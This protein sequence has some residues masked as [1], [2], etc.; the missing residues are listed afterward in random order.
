MADLNMDKHFEYAGVDAGDTSDSASVASTVDTTNEGSTDGIDVTGGDSAEGEKPKLEGQDASKEDKKQEAAAKDRDSGKPDGD[1]KQGE[2]KKEG[3]GASSAGDLTLQDGTVIKAGAE[4]RWYDAARV[5]RQ[6]T[7]ATKN[8]LNTINQKYQTLEA[9][10]NTLVETTKQIGLED[11]TQVQASVRLYKDLN[12]D[13]VG[14]VTKLL[15]ELRGLGHNVDGIGGA[16]DNAVLQSLNQRISQLSEGG[17]QEQQQ[18]QV[19]QQQEQEIQAE[20]N[21]FVATFPDAITHEEM[22]SQVVE[23]DAAKGISTSLQDAYFR[24]KQSAIA[25][26]YD[27]SQ[28]LGPQVDARRNAN[29]SQQQQQ[30]PAPRPNGR[31][32]VVA[33]TVENINPVKNSNNDSLDTDSIIVAAM[34]ENGLNYQR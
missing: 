13:P 3:Q 2:E 10:H 30:N 5:A 6:E 31:P 19:Q 28:P 32:G 24:L 25:Q 17:N 20:V 1:K 15:A 9:R 29:Q 8:Q 11:A 14:T 7:V 21:Q 34:R 16:V 12:R 18:Q 26:G 33:E 27:W 23:A 4:R 22:I